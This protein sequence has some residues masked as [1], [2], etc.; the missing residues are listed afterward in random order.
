METPN[1]KVG[2]DIVISGASKTFRRGDNRAMETH[3]LDGVDLT[4]AAS[5]FVAIVGP[6]GCGKSTL[7]QL[8]SGLLEPTGGEIVIGGKTVNGP[9]YRSWHCVP[10]NRFCWNGA[11]Y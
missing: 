4:I 1:T 9:A 11:V 7:L 2:T 3:A 5:E 8:V 10:K 6:S